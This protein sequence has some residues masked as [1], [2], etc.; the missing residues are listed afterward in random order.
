MESDPGEP[1]NQKPKLN[2]VMNRFRAHCKGWGVVYNVIGQLAVALAVI[3]TAFS[4]IFTVF[5]L[6]I[7]RDA[8]SQSSKALRLSQKSLDLQRKEF[9]IRNRPIVVLENVS[10]SGPAKWPDGFECEKSVAFELTNVSDIPANGVRVIASAFT[11]NTPVPLPDDPTTTSLARDQRIPRALPIEETTIAFATNG[12]MQ[13]RVVFDVTYS[14][15]FGG[16]FDN[17]K[18]HVEMH[19]MPKEKRFEITKSSFQ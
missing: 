7:S 3:I 17:Y 10:F 19:Y 16:S 14:G 5:G 18:T 9:T 11:D 4:L 13:F 1:M 15:M 8:V 6:R 12:V 2:K